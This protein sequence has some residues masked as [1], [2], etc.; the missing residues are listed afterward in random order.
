[1]STVGDTLAQTQIKLEAEYVQAKAA[2]ETKL[3]EIQAEIEATK[4]HIAH[5]G[6]WLHQEM[7]EA[8]DAIVAFFGKFGL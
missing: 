4:T 3:A 6:P 7:T 2:G 8:K 1:M 5:F